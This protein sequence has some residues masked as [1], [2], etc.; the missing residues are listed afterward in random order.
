[1]TSQTV[2]PRRLATTSSC[3]A[4]FGH[5]FEMQA[6]TLKA[7][8]RFVTKQGHPGPLTGDLAIA[9]VLACEVDTQRAGTTARGASTFRGVPH[10]LSIR[11]PGCSTPR[12]YLGPEQHRQRG[13]STTPS[14]RDSWPRARCDGRNLMRGRTLYTLFASSPAPVCAPGRR[15]ASIRTDV[16]SPAASL[17]SAR[18]SFAKTA[19]SP[20]I[21]QH[22]RNSRPMLRSATAPSLG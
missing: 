2:S 16:T 1:V 15:C 3:A 5:A 14:W 22:V 9:F 17:R 21:P 4:R 6:A 13:F 8:H 18:P 20:S 10:G 7:F 19:S 11:L 12:R